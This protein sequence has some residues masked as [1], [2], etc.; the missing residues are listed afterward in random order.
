VGRKISTNSDNGTNPK[1]VQEATQGSNPVT[2]NTSNSKRTRLSQSDV[3][4]YSL[5]DALRIPRAIGDNYAYR[6]TRP[7][8][9]A[10]A[11]GVQPTSG[12]FRTL[13]GT[14][15][16]Y[17]LTEGGPNA[18]VISVTQLA[19]NILMPQEEGKDLQARR[20]AL[21]IPRVI[22]EFLNKYNGYKLPTDD[23]AK[24]VLFTMGVPKEALDR[25][26][27]LIINSARSVGFLRDN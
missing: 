20:Q 14:A 6:P 22:N 8:D 17:G 1:T 25:T 11:L 2:A 24:N 12:P 13:A 16:A 26:L 19:R 23:I 27:K 4:S 9:V 3:P 18:P 7:L 5:D 15:I 21:L 10:M